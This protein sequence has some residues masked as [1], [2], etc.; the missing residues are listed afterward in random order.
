MKKT[1]LIIAVLIALTG[2]AQ[3][4]QMTYDNNG[5]DTVTQTYSSGTIQPG[6]PSIIPITF[7]QFNTMGGT[8][9][10]TSVTVSVTQQTWGGTYEA[11]NDSTG[12]ETATGSAQHGISG[13]VTVTALNY[14]FLP[15]TSGNTLASRV[16]SGQFTL[17]ANDDNLGVFDPGPGADHYKLEGPAQGSALSAS[18]NGTWVEADGTLAAYQGSG[19]LSMDYTVTQSSS[20]TGTG[21]ISYS[22]T[23]ASSSTEIIVTYTYTPEPTSLALFA[24]GCAVL[25]MRRRT[26]STLKI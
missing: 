15:G 4:V 3:A 26:R 21:A 25:G 8:R 20:Y 10:L 17:A 6:S 18:G 19:N 9:T 12:G 11:D 2:V 22:G 16:N 23:A 24:M 1:N 5:W 7:A 13:R 14:Y